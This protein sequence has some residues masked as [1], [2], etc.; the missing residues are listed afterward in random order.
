MRIVAPI[1][2]NWPSRWFAGRRSCYRASLSS[3]CAR[4]VAMFGRLRWDGIHS[5]LSVLGI[6]DRAQWVQ[7]GSIPTMR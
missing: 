4:G 7:S 1:W 6:R 3:C 2:L 5:V